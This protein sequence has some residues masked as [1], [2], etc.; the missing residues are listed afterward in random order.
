MNQVLLRCTTY[1]K[2]ISHAESI[3]RLH[4]TTYAD[5][6]N[7]RI[8]QSFFT[9]VNEIAFEQINNLVTSLYHETI[10][11]CVYALAKRMS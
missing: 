8:I 7:G 4:L 9:L 3:L 6:R 5:I 11:F 2:T 1:H 10:L